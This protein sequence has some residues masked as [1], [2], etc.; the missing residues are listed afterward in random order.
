MFFSFIACC[1]VLPCGKL[2]QSPWTRLCLWHWLLSV[3]NEV[4][5]TY[6]YAFVFSRG[7]KPWLKYTVTPLVSST[8][9]CLLDFACFFDL[10]VILTFVNVTVLL[11]THCNERRT[12]KLERRIMGRRQYPSTLATQPNETPVIL[13]RLRR[14]YMPRQPIALI[15]YT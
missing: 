13:I 6:L 12:A 8:K 5:E 3:Q 1:D 10:Q 9:Q 4:K 14:Q 2:P 7:N 11:C 15:P